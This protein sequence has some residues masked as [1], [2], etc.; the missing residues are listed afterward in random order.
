M[1]VETP[2]PLLSVENLSIDYGRGRS[3]TRVVTDVSFDIAE[4][5]T[6]GLVGESGSGKSTI[7]KAILGLVPVAEGAVRFDGEDISRVSPR[8]RRELTRAIQVIYQDPYGSLNPARQVGT[9]LAEPLTLRRGELSRRE[10]SQRVGDALELVGLPSTAA[11]K[12]PGDFSG[13]QRQRIA[14][15]R[16]VIVRPRLIVCDEAVSALDLSIQAQVLNLLQDLSAELGMSYLF[17]SHD[18]AVVELL[19]SRIAVLYRGSIVERGDA[20]QLLEQPQAPYTRLL[21]AAAPVP[22]PDEQRRRR[23]EFFAAFRSRQSA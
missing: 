15:A 14:I 2:H 7:G 1:P 21:Q 8:R 12:Y 4:G 3:R 18:L 16:A 17:I 20:R 22:D 19:S 11:R 6:L 5:E 23:E 10:I 13:G 9:T